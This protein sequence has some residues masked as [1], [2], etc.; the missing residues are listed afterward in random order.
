MVL[1]QSLRRT[2]A[3]SVGVI[4]DAVPEVHRMVDIKDRVNA[5]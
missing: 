1:P 2:I 4:H 5:P 3:P